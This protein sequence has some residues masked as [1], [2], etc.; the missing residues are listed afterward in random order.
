MS[1]CNKC[2]DKGYCC[3]NFIIQSH[4]PW[5]Y[6]AIENKNKVI[7]RLKESNLSFFIPVK[8]G[9]RY[10]VFSCS[11]ITDEGKCSV[12]KSRPNL[13]RE[14]RPATGDLCVMSKK[15]REFSGY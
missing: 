14:Y 5:A 8:K 2:K 3:R 6:T 13:C 12:Y 9:K 11:K 4:E 15:F 1:I 7:K 10:W